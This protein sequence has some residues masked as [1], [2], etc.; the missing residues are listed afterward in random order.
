MSQ[1]LINQPATITVI[2]T[3][4]QGN[5]VTGL[6]DADAVLFY[7]KF[8]GIPTEKTLTA[9]NFSEIDAT[10]LPGLYE[11]S[12]TG[13]ELDTEGE[14]V[15]VLRPDGVATFEQ[16][17]VRL[18]VVMATAKTVD[19]RLISFDKTTSN[20][21]QDT[22][23]TLLVKLNESGVAF[24]DVSAEVIKGDGSTQTLTID[25]STWIEVVGST[26]YYVLTLP[27]T[28]TN[29]VG[30]LVVIVTTPDEMV[31][32]KIQVVENNAK[33]VFDSLEL[34]KGVGF[35]SNTDSLTE[36]RNQIEVANSDLSVVITEIDNVISELNTIKGT[37][38]VVE[39]DDLASI[40]TAVDAVSGS[41]DL[42]AI[43][44]SLE[45][46]KG[47]GFASASDA[48]TV[49]REQLDEKAE[50]AAL[51]SVAL[52]LSEAREDIKR[53]LGLSK[54][55]FR[56][57]GQEYTTANKLREATIEIFETAVDVDSGTP[58][59]TY[60]MSADYDS[61]GRLINYEV[62]KN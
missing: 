14:F 9:S 59:A 52:E 62:K 10:N 19:K 32:Q 53:V 61:E 26:G 12:F 21:R 27:D 37:Q 31:E 56:I 13:T 57:T 48:L 49:L 6:T 43:E 60:A 36:L 54:E 58:I 38:F 16:V 28:S 45:E 47:T 8:D 35:T 1:T 30:E 7:R 5:R 24:G 15:A 18:E 22:G 55:N 3:D 51:A 25:S 17:E 4:D 29:V 2:I 34:V 23:Y 41:I 33:D 50:A 39:E 20:I 44:Q 40:K 42:S 46:I 11:V